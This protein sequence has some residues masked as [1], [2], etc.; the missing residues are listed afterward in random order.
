MSLG[1]GCGYKPASPQRYVNFTLISNQSA[2]FC[3]ALGKDFVNIF[4]MWTL[5]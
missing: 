1:F 3:A 2:P 4:F 5:P